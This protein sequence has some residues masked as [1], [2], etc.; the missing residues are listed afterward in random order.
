MFPESP[1]FSRGQFN[2]QEVTQ[3]DLNAVDKLYKHVKNPEKSAKHW[4]NNSDVKNSAVPTNQNKHTTKPKSK[5][6]NDSAKLK[7]L[8]ITLLKSLWNILV[9][10]VKIIW[11]LIKMLINWIAHIITGWL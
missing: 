4:G 1:D 3:K 7:A 2:K 8:G 9:D 11:I 10:L 5:N 6:T